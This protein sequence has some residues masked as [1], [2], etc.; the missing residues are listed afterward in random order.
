MICKTV[1]ILSLIGLLFSAG[2]RCLSSGCCQTASRYALSR[3]DEGRTF[4]I[5]SDH[6]GAL[7]PH[8]IAG[9]TLP[10]L[11]TDNRIGESF[12]LPV[13]EG[14]DHLVTLPR[15]YSTSRRLIVILTVDEA[16]YW[17]APR[18]VA[19]WRLAFVRL[20]EFTRMGERRF[21]RPG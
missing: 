3:K 18:Q 17:A 16:R 20:S 14:E 21:L 11:I 19:Q 4:Q 2:L 10:G 9:T 6:P 5:I 15:D 1:T 13:R 8:W 7:K 12:G